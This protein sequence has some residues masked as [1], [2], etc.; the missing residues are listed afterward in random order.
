MQD[1]LT[2]LGYCLRWCL[3][4]ITFLYLSEKGVFDKWI[5]FVLRRSSEGSWRTD[6]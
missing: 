3:A 4:G 5:D 6:I 1:F 2:V